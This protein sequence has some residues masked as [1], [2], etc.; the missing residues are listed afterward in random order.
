M[1]LWFLSIYDLLVNDHNFLHLFNRDILGLRGVFPHG[2]QLDS[3][4]RLNFF[5]NMFFFKNESV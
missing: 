5:T 4:L 3:R 2:K 1:F